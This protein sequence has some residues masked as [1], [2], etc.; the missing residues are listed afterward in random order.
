VPEE[1]SFEKALSD[2]APSKP[3]GAWN[4]VGSENA[5]ARESTSEG[6][7]SLAAGLLSGLLESVRAATPDQLA[8]VHRL[9][10]VL[11]YYQL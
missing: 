9:D 11:Y 6:D 10:G 4:A 5:R 8:G 2:A 3:P 1:G 7:L